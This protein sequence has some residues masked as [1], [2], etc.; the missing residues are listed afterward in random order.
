MNIYYLGH[1]SFLIKTKNGKRILTDPFKIDSTLGSVDIVTVSHPHFDHSDIDTFPDKSKILQLPSSYENNFC[2]IETFNSYHDNSLGTKR[3]S[4]LI[5]FFEID[6]LTLCHLGDLGHTLD[7]P[8][9]RRLKNIDVLFVPVGENYTI[10]LKSLS[11]M[12]NTINPKYILPMH[13]RTKDY[14]LSLNTLDKF[15]L[16]FKNYTKE[17]LDTL[18]ISED[19]ISNKRNQIIIL[20]K[21]KV[22][23]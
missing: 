2:R 14:N 20:D 15:L 6:S 23:V 3:G 12:I 9:V 4:N 18:L 21:I 8:I 7:E 5:F 22:D 16:I 10:D 1:S 17:K 13:Y 19:D 11:K